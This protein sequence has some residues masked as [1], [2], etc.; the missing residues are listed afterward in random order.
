MDGRRRV[1]A[2]RQERGLTTSWRTRDRVKQTELHEKAYAGAENRV[3]P[4]PLPDASEYAGQAG[5]I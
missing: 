5:L 3:K 1:D 4:D 2:R